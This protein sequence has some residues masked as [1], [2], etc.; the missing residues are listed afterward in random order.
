MPV[1]RNVSY[2]ALLGM[3]CAG[4]GQLSTPTNSAENGSSVFVSARLGKKAGECAEDIIDDGKAAMNADVQKIVSTMNHARR[5]LMNTGDKK[6]QVPE[7]VVMGEQSMGKS[8]L[9]ETIAGQRFNF[10]YGDTATMR[11]THIFFKNDT[12][13]LP[14]GRVQWAI[15]ELQPDGSVKEVPYDTAALQLQLA[16]LHTRDNVDASEIELVCRSSEQY[17]LDLIDLPG[18]MP[19]DANADP[20]DK[21][22]TKKITDMMKE[23]M[24]RENSRI[25]LVDKIRDV[26]QI[27]IIGSTVEKWLK[28]ED[29]SKVTYV[30]TMLDTESFHN[31]RDVNHYLNAIDQNGKIGKLLP[32]M[33]SV[34]LSCP[35]WKD[36]G[37]EAAVTITDD[38]FK[39]QIKMRNDDDV[40]KVMTKQSE[41]RKSLGGSGAQR[42][43]DD[44]E[45]LNRIGFKNFMR[46]FQK[47]VKSEFTKKLKPVADQ[48]SVK[49]SM[50]IDHVNDLTEKISNEKSKSG[51]E[52]TG[53][54]VAKAVSIVLAQPLEVH[55]NRI[56][57]SDSE[58]LLNGPSL[59]EDIEEFCKSVAFEDVFPI[60]VQKEE[61]GGDTYDNEMTLK[62]DLKKKE[63]KYRA[64][65][66]KL[67][68]DCRKHAQRVKD[69]D[70]K[71]V[72]EGKPTQYTSSKLKYEA[73][74]LDLSKYM[75]LSDPGFS[76]E[77]A[78]E[79]VGNCAAD[80]CSGGQDKFTARKEAVKTML[81]DYG[82]PMLNGHLRMVALRMKQFLMEQ[83]E[84][85]KVFATETL[86]ATD[87]D[88]ANAR[89]AA[90]ADWQKLRNELDAM[91]RESVKTSV[92]NRYEQYLEALIKDFRKG[93]QK[94]LR[95]LMRDPLSLLRAPLNAG[96]EFGIPVPPHQYEGYDESN[97]FVV[98][99]FARIG[100]QEKTI[101]DL[102]S[103]KTEPV[104]STEE[105]DETTGLKVRVKKPVDRFGDADRAA[106]A[107]VD[108]AT[109]VFRAIRYKVS[110]SLDVHLEINFFSKITML[111]QF[112]RVQRPTD[113]GETFEDFMNGMNKDMF[114]VNYGELR[115]LEDEKT[116]YAKNLE[117]VTT[118]LDQLLDL[119]PIVD[120]MLDEL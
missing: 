39:R 2:C 13:I 14:A 28:P 47:D 100:A 38:E 64:R 17:D 70:E 87:T 96:N 25:M 93:T 99:E 82:L 54:Y 101:A 75:F 73:L 65:Y 111:G 72:R 69:S 12:S 116:K 61:F 10:V 68:E 83:V 76:V 50:L 46:I 108:L 85:A 34:A 40:S 77:D 41:M 98:N 8:R 3:L 114:K 79:L 88:L 94:N 20:I 35:W 21:A 44:A 105:I 119:K 32:G 84:R 26:M 43:E 23:Y 27:K 58:K 55:Y 53:K 49:K 91:N 30:R 18:K 45:V 62:N 4:Y 104:E 51:G 57:A 117:E 120:G 11:P 56:K 74:G 60:D 97:S 29:Y 113:K 63:V 103:S 115:K 1:V 92:T 90:G 5:I 42:T 36:E 95:S 33:K 86:P 31:K 80:G 9:I 52:E 16:E 66:A 112:R 22:N 106:S 107:I 7:F 109:Q 19:D 59:S 6:T 78:K 37:S 15:N 71:L 24:T 48:M 118:S 110:E 102:F 89:K 81:I 67:M